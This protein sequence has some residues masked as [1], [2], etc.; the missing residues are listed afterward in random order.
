MFGHT[1]GWGLVRFPYRLGLVVG[2]IL[3]AVVWRAR[4]NKEKLTMSTETERVRSPREIQLSVA[5]ARERTFIFHFLEMQIAMGLGAL[6]CYLLTRLI[7]ASS[8]F[9]TIYHPGT[10][11]Y[12]VGDILFLTVPVVAWM[13]FRGYGWRHSLEMALAMV[14]P[15]AAIIMVGELAG[16][17]YLLWLITAMYPAMSLGMLVYMLYRRDQFTLRVGYRTHVARP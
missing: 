13:I 7:P 16:Y 10:Y 6:V 15:V 1:S 17:A 3:R 12:A 4:E 5:V 2:G 8:S 11:L 14:A 9:A